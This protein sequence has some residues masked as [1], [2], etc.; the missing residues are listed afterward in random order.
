MGILQKLKD[1]FARQNRAREFEKYSQSISNNPDPQYRKASQYYQS[2]KFRNR[3][4]PQGVTKAVAS[5]GGVNAGGRGGY[6]RKGR[7]KGAYSGRYAAYGGVYGYRKYMAQQRRLELL[8][9]Q[10]QLSQ[11]QQNPHGRQLNAPRPQGMP[12]QQVISHPE[13]QQTQPS[14]GISL[15]DNSFMKLDTGQSN[16]Q[17]SNVMMAAFNPE[18]PSGEKEGDYYTEPDFF[19][20]KQVMRRRSGDRLFKW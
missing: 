1:K 3:N 4:V 20:G 11:E 12:P 14:T 17:K 19:S 16:I 2:N 10:Q 15:W 9:A 18:T 13:P 5:L 7:P 6:G 8:K